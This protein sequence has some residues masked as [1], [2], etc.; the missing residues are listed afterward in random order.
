MYMTVLGRRIW[1]TEKGTGQPVVL[2]HGYLE[3]S[4]IWDNFA[5]SLSADCRVISIDLPGHGRSDVYN[6][7]H[8]ME[9]MADAVKSLTSQLKLDKFF[10]VG[11]S[12]GG[13]V[14]LAFLEH[15]PEDLYGYCLFHS[16]PL[17]D[18]EEAVQKRMNEIAMVLSGKK[19]LMYPDN[20]EKMFAPS[21]LD[22]LKDAVKKSKRIASENPG[23]G[24]I[25]VLNGMMKRPSRVEVMEQ[26]KVP[27][28]WILGAKDK[29][30]DHLAI[31]QKVKLPGNTCTEVLKNSGHMGFI[32]EQELSVKLILEFVKNISFT[33]SV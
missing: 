24:I 22:R 32:E 23:N 3:S 12:L 6:D 4:E 31:Q 28:L 18:S 11:H 27:G 13:Y 19:D 1:Y 7:T 29:Y 20:I 16:H 17:P 9:M 25:A 26:G 15:Y 2:L 10:L 14:T 33:A 8:T 21:N 30:I 5:E